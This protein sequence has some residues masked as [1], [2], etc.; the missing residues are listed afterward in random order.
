MT[1][2]D[3]QQETKALALGFIGVGW[4]G[5]NRMEVLVN[6]GKAT[7]AA[8]SEPYTENAN[9]ALETAP[10]AHILDNPEL[11]YLNS[12]LDGVVIATPSALH[13]EQ[14]KSALDSGKAVFCQKPLGR[15]AA[16]VRDV[17]NASKSANK[18]LGVDLSYRYTKAFNSV[19]NVVAGGQIGKIFAVDLI[20]HNAY[21][22]DKEWFYDIKR[23]GGGCV[24]D[25]GIHLVDLALW[26]LGFPDVTKVDSHLFSKG[27][28]LAPNEE[29]VEDFAK[30]SMLTGDHTSISL[31]C[32][33]NVS[34]G[35]DAVIEARFYGTGGGA[36]F[37]NINGSFYDFQAERYNGTQTE[38]LASPPD[39]WSGRAGVVWAERILNG[40]GFDAETATEFIKTAEVI[41][42]IY[43]RRI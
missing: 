7:A 16:E 15:T 35:Q 6:S 37:R 2:T 34:A 5:R 20:F 19:Y 1:L 32:S 22:P 25:L 21:G 26:S 24:M 23:S 29:Q 42:R 43:G 4:I 8:I 31:K 11:I 17:V 39:D 36:A 3:Q 33:W 9:A 27:R 40:T 18:L 30:V 28:K 13:A 38:I 12:S 41:D 10:E 14:S